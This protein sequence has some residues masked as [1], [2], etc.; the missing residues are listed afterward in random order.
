MLV[1]LA[2]FLRCC[3]RS[4]HGECGSRQGRGRALLARCAGPRD[5]RGWFY[6][7][8]APS[9]HGLCSAGVTI[10]VASNLVPEGEAGGC[11]WLC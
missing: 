6:D 11:R 5:D 7:T 3:R 10:Y 1:F 2:V 4:G 9:A 8:V